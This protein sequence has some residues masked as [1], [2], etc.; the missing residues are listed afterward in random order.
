MNKR[1]VRVFVAVTLSV[2]VLGTAGWLQLRGTPPEAHASSSRIDGARATP[3]PAA[4]P[5]ATHLWVG[6]GLALSGEIRQPATLSPGVRGALLGVLGQ[7]H[8]RAAIS[9]LVLSQRV[10][11]NI[12]AI[13]FATYRSPVGRPQSAAVIVGALAPGAIASALGQHGTATTGIE[14][15]RAW[16]IALPSPTHCPMHTR[17]TTN[18]VATLQYVAIGPRGRLTPVL[19]SLNKHG[20]PPSRWRASA[21]LHLHLRVPPLAAGQRGPVRPQSLVI[22]IGGSADAA[23]SGVAYGERLSFSDA[24]S[25]SLWQH[26]IGGALGVVGTPDHGLQ[27][28][29]QGVHVYLRGKL[30]PDTLT[31]LTLFS[32]EGTGSVVGA[33]NNALWTMLRG[34]L[35]PP[36]SH[37]EDLSEVTPLLHGTLPSHLRGV[38]A[39]PFRVSVAD[40]RLRPTSQALTLHV[41]AWGPPLPNLSD[42]AGRVHI[43]VTGAS[44]DCAS[45]AQLERIDKHT[46]VFA[47]RSLDVPQH[48]N[49]SAPLKGQIITDIPASVAHLD[50]ALNSTL[51][52]ALGP[53]AQLSAFDVHGPFVSLV[54]H[55]HPSRLLHMR[56]TDGAGKRVRATPLYVGQPLGLPAPGDLLYVLQLDRPA[57][58]IEAYYAHRLIRQSYAFTLAHRLPIQPA[59]T[60][61]HRV[62]ALTADAALPPARCRRGQAV[63]AGPLCV[64]VRQLGTGPS[65]MLM[66]GVQAPAKAALAHRLF[67]GRIR[68]RA[69]VSSAGRAMTLGGAGPTTRYDTPVSFAS[70]ISATTTRTALITLY[71]AHPTPTGQTHALGALSI[72]TPVAV[73]HLTIGATPGATLTAGSARV[74]L[75]SVSRENYRFAITGDPMRVVRIVPYNAKGQ[76]LVA[77]TVVE[78]SE[79]GASPAATVDIRTGAVDHFGVE[80]ATRL[81]AREYAFAIPLPKP[82]I[83]GQAHP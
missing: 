76:P 55:G 43:A 79:D 48:S 10:G 24:H 50:G 81:A 17:H 13:E 52:L 34:V 59:N 53:H 21:P 65:T 6:Q 77:Q 29:Q 26:A 33:G 78:S 57:T 47:S 28:R 22:A 71:G 63:A 49:L 68:L 19:E 64:G 7:L 2:V 44:P 51:S 11:G 70:T 82:G 56:F 75:V 39:G 41:Q 18:V 73:K 9:A 23:Q 35:S 72:E 1:N 27:L 60:P 3:G 45:I 83:L 62:R 67:A 42:I 61:A 38:K 31:A 16:D 66:L 12:K 15:R 58:S 37:Y 25:A 80:V 4:P 30:P 46:V 8:A 5:L 40:A 74:Q 14:D 20:I 69:L 32:L 36:P 54:Y